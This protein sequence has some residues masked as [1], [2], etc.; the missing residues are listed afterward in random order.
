MRVVLIAVM[1][2]SAAA[3]AQT[4]EEEHEEIRYRSVTA[5]DFTEVEIRGAMVGPAVSY[6]PSR[7]RKRFRSLIELRAN[8]APELERSAGAL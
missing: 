4:G 3:V 6:L 8:F 2:V 5:I 7:T 1:L